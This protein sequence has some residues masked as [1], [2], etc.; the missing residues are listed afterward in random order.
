[1]LPAIIANTASSVASVKD[2]SCKQREKAS[3]ALD[4]ESTYPGKCAT[5]GYSD[6]LVNTINRS[7]NACHRYPRLPARISRIPDI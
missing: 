3:D 5:P 7:F 6:N 2:A 4:A 1:M